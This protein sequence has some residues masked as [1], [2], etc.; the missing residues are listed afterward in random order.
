MTNAVQTKCQLKKKKNFNVF[1]EHKFRT[2]LLP[3]PPLFNLSGVCKSSTVFIEQSFSWFLFFVH[4][5]QTC[6]PSAS[7]AGEN[8]HTVTTLLS[9][10][11][12]PRNWNEKALAGRTETSKLV[13]GLCSLICWNK[14]MLYLKHSGLPD[15]THPALHHVT[16][17]ENCYKPAR[18][19]NRAWN[20]I[21]LF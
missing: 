13:F 4:C 19:P 21:S 7:R 6:L 15:A 14:R 18:E 1:K 3:L 20:P 17:Q 5:G 10:D 9:A 12:E 8:S 11:C 2:K 16:L